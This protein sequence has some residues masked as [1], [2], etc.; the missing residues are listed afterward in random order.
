MTKA[1][2]NTGMIVVLRNGEEYMVMLD[3]THNYSIG[4]NDV[5]VGLEHKWF[6]VHDYNENMLLESD[7][8]YDIMEVYM[9]THPYAFTDF[10][11]DKD[12]RILLWKREEVEIKKMTVADIEKLVGCKVEIVKEI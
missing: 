1:D 4:C 5:L 9:V 11:Y 10:N 7:H 3:S 12:K 6:K 2:L 8:E